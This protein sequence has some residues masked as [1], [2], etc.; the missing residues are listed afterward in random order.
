[1]R[2]L[3]S[4]LSATLLHPF[5]L[6]GLSWTLLLVAVVHAGLLTL[7]YGQI[8][9]DIG[10]AFTGAE[11]LEAGGRPF[12]DFV[13]IN[14]PP[15]YELGRLPL[16]ISAWTGLDAARAS[17]I[18]YFL[19]ML[20]PLG[21]CAWLLRRTGD[22][23]ASA[24]VAATFVMVWLQV[25]LG[26]LYVMQ[27]GQ[28]D[29]LVM[30]FLLPSILLSAIRWSGSVP[31]RL[32]SALAGCCAVIALL[33]K[34][35]YI[36]VLILLELSLR[37]KV[38]ELRRRVQLE[39]VV[40]FAG[41]MLS[42]MWLW[43][44][45]GF[46]EYLFTW[47][48]LFAR[49][50]GVY[51]TSLPNVVEYL[52]TDV[53]TRFLLLGAFPVALILHGR[54][55]TLQHKLLRVLLLAGVAVL[56]IYFLQGKGWFY[57]RLPIWYVAGGVMA[58]GFAAWVTR[59]ERRPWCVQL[60]PAMLLLAQFGMMPR[61]HT[62]LPR[63]LEQ[64]PRT[65]LSDYLRS[66]TRNGDRIAVFSMSVWPASPAYAYARR[67]P[68]LRYSMAFPVA[69][70]HEGAG[71]W[72]LTGERKWMADTYYRH[73]L[74]DVARHHP[75]VIAIDTVL[76][77]RKVPADFSMDNWLRRRGFH[78]SVLQ[79]YVRQSPVMNLQV[80]LRRDRAVGF[81]EGMHP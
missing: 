30:V 47:T 21:T 1:M 53:I 58:L 43:S 61:L 35:Q 27:Y 75:V 26:V 3:F 64:K 18:G 51:G 8:D 73:V 34:P 48:P 50:Y 12:K 2:S 31:A 5:L 46:H 74:E 72:A 57:H 45:P 60:V 68:A 40:I 16:R 6:A 71:T 67:L 15:I 10:V 32:P 25:G 39:H 80:Y 9:H 69:M 42:A 11:V 77:F 29:Q 14:P 36:L 24:A 63:M 62:Q 4:R 56:A 70:A 49:Y 23:P 20:L 66:A 22:T 33:V 78:D 38:P 19:V 28:R 17:G 81:R 7:G 52:S 76:A 37:W 44:M 54:A 13:D 55:D 59:K 65:D 41:A 79:D